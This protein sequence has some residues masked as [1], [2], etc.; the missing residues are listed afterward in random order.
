GA[1]ATHM[2]KPFG[3]L[4]G[5]GTHFHISLWDGSRDRNLFLD[6]RDSRGLGLSALAYQFLGG[7]MEHA[8]ALAAVR[9]PTV[10]DDKRLSVGAFLT[11]VPAGYTGPPAFISYG[12]NNR[13]QMFRVPEPGRF[14]CRLVS[15]SVNPSLG[16]AAF[17]AA[18]LDGIRRKLDPGE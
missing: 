6:E 14:E 8:P 2:P 11:G 13:P 17:V 15:G 10:N 4:T 18:G 5:S 16:M 3:N 1:I 9:A 7:V 12:A